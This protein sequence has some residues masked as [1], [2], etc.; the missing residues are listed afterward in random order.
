VDISLQLTHI[1]LW[2]HSS[3]DRLIGRG[4]PGVFSSSW[5]TIS[6]FG[7]PQGEISRSPYDIPRVPPPGG[8]SKLIP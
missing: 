2:E 3:H 7:L 4:V 1:S 5:S 6:L 8:E